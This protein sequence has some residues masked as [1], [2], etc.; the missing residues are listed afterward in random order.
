MKGLIN[1]ISVKK[2]V[3]GN[4]LLLLSMIFIIS[5]YSLFTMGQIGK[6]LEAIAEQ[7]IPLTEILTKITE[8]QLEQAI[9]FERAVKYGVIIDIDEGAQ[10]HLDREI[11][12]FDKLSARVDEEI[13]QGEVLSEE[14]MAHASNETN[15]KEFEHI[16]QTLKIIEKEHHDFEVHVHQVFKAILAG[17][18]HKAIELSSSI[19]HEEE[20]LYG[21]LEALLTNVEE[22]TKEAGK[23]AEQHEI[24]AIW[25][26]GTIVLI[27]LIIGILTSGII[28]SNIV[29][30]LNK[31]KQSIATIADGDLTH[32]IIVDGTDEIGHL[33][34]SMQTMRV[35]ILEM[36]SDIRSTSLELASASEEVSATMMQTAINIQS[37]QEET[38]HISSAMT[39]MSQ[40]VDEVSRNVIDTSD[41]SNHANSE[42]NNGQSIVQ[43]TIDEIQQL[44]Q[45]IDNASD[46]VAQLE[47]G[48][49]KVNTVMDVI[50]GIAEQTNLLALNAAIEAARAGEQGRGFAVVADEVR[51]LASRTQE[52]TSEINQIIENLQTAAKEANAVMEGSKEQSHSAVNKATTAGSSLNTITTS[53]SKID[54]MSSRI[55]T[56]AEEQNA[57]AKNL[58]A[59]IGH[60]NE[61]AMQNAASIEQ[62]TVAG[63][64]IAS[65][66]AQ[67]Q[68]LVE[69]FRVA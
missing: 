65:R 35:K 42:A 23:R 48:N 49:E 32:E 45:Q 51:T 37:Q 57:V 18:R 46:V 12:A 26:L 6:E 10:K 2:K 27:S 7:D 28:S 16:H 39:E 53:I 41:E 43:E 8:H 3:I 31:S 25:T 56:A 38:E 36:I 50:K 4:S 54:D 20:Q 64:E 59:N 69:Q 68:S 47:Q 61:I 62:T 24:S 63:Q 34:I 1:R 33:F 60:I 66:A 22:F 29:N 55:A 40:A 5:I 44:S 14:S 30:R 11:A 19:E 52:S 15:R 58:D 17:D 9:H 13:I 67:L 21:V